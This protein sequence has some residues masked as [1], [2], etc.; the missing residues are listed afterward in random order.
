MLV[1]SLL[2]MV[3][4][5]NQTKLCKQFIAGDL[6]LPHTK[7]VNSWIRKAKAQLSQLSQLSELSLLLWVVQITQSSNDSC[8]SCHRVKIAELLLS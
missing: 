1:N 7:T 2:N 6:F 4:L 3:Q 5:V 8:H